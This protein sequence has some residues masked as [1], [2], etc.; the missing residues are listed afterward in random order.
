MN[1]SIQN[2]MELMDLKKIEC[3]VGVVTL[4]K[5]PLSIELETEL[6]DIPADYIRV[7]ETKELDKVAVKELYK[8]KGIMLPGIKYNTDSKSLRI[9]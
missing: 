7:K 2:A 5:A 3:S 9:K 8:E 4:A 6:D 1:D